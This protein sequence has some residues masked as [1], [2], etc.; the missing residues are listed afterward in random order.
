MPQS[1]HPKATSDIKAGVK[2]TGVNKDQ[3]KKSITNK[4]MEAMAEGAGNPMV[5]TPEFEALQGLPNAPF[6]VKL[7]EVLEKFKTAQGRGDFGKDLKGYFLDKDADFY[8]IGKQV[9]EET[10]ANASLLENFYDEDGIH[11]GYDLGKSLAK[12]NL[13]RMR[14]QAPNYIN[15]EMATR[16]NDAQFTTLVD[17]L[18]G[19]PNPSTAFTDFRRGKNY[20][21]GHFTDTKKLIEHIMEFYK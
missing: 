9:H 6:R 3:I 5:V 15:L 2:T 4:W 1:L 17:Y 20:S 13:I 11:T 8:D 14:Q 18:Q 7:K 12:N 16:P 21:G 19:A 10:L